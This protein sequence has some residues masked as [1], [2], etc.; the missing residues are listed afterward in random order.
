MVKV[1]H[2]TEA[3]IGKVDAVGLLRV[4]KSFPPAT[5]EPVEDVESFAVFVGGSE[6]R[7]A[8][9]GVE[10]EWAFLFVEN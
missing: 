6:L 1:V 10:L 4:L 2:F 8:R 5:A 3:H 9:D 7:I